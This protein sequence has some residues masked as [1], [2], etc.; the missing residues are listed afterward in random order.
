MIAEHEDAAEL[1]PVTPISEATHVPPPDDAPPVG[2]WWWVKGTGHKPSEYDEPGRKYLACVVEV[3]S[4]YAKVKGVTF[5]NRLSLDEFHDLCKP[6][7]DPGAYIDRK[8][9]FRKSRVRKLM[10]E[11]QRICHLLG[12]PLRDVLAPGA[13]APA[14]QAL[15]IVHGTADVKA[16]QKSLI[17]AKDKTLPE[18]FAKI[19]EEHEV[20][21][22]WMSAELIP[23]DAEL[24][25]V[26]EVR[27]VIADKIHTVELYAGLQEQLVQV[28]EGAPAS[29]E[30][31][32]HLMQ[33]RHYMDEECLARYEAGGMRFEDIKD[34]D[35][36]IARDENFTRLL[37]HD[38][39]IVAFRV[40]HYDRR[41][42]GGDIASFIAL[43]HE[44]QDNKRTYL[45]IRNGRQLWRMSTA[46]SFDENLFPRREDSD[47]LGDDDLWIKASEYDL[48]H[49]SGIITGRQR[50]AKIADRRS[51]RAFVAQALWQWHRAGKP[52]EHWLYTAIAHEHEQWNWKPGE[53]HAQ[54]GAPYGTWRHDR[55]HADPVGDYTLLTPTNI[56]YD[57]AMKRI[58]RAAFEHNRIA[59]IVQGLLD[60]STCLH[61]HAPWRIWTPEGFAAGIE[62]VYDVSLGITPGD[63]PNFEEYRA[64]LN[65]SIRAGCYTIGQ[66]GAWASY[67]AKR[68]GQKW[69]DYI[70]Y[71]NKGPGRIARVTRV[72]RDGSCEFKW[73]RSRSKAKWIRNPKRPGYMMAVYP[74][75]DTGWV[76]P[77]E[78][79]T[80]VDAYTP[81]DYR[82]FFD[83]PRTR[84][85]YLRWAPILLAA[86]D[87]H[88]RRRTAP[89][90]ADEED[91]SE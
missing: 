7:R 80:C 24:T 63:A 30:T 31:R 3:G 1:A 77:A 71:D 55:L 17:K 8:V 36:W 75:I 13:E 54:T 74:P 32:V 12:V 33:R 4:N 66:S 40:R 19:K 49:G 56:Y 79:L 84:A 60:R 86:E 23:M 89:D 81:G 48:E 68:Y 52:E 41:E 72:K 22:K 26:K 73:T 44:N 27:G 87:W 70:R 28:R 37:P 18:L 46:I 61:P 35:K 14:T 62:L 20:M 29:I 15:A 65:R 50:A 67:M 57:D 34:F 91:D 58:Q 59:V 69:R 2:S 76:C 6:E 43:W 9:G 51:R 85:N 39:T 83:D 90:G 45:Y 88:A 78:H 64:Q 10:A 16:Y 82:L 47:L 5:S 42:E 21:A 11:I 53:V 25:A 38:R